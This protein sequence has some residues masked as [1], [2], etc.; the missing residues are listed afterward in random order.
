MKKNSNAQIDKSL[1]G[2]SWTRRLVTQIL[3]L[4]ALACLLPAAR[5]SATLMLSN[6]WSLAQGSRYYLPNGGD[7]RG[8]GM[9]PVTGDILIP[10][11]QGGSN[12]VAVL[13]A[14]GNDLGS[15]SGSGVTAARRRFA[16]SERPTMESSTAATWPPRARVS[17][18]TAGLRKM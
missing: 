4:A 14:N 8:V 16:W 9:N 3:A 5:G 6:I 15:L 10:S 1:A 2:Q 13:D 7:P 11:I 18:F 12:H 17:S